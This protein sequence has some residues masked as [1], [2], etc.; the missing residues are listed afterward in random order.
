MSCVVPGRSVMC[1]LLMYSISIEALVTIIA[2]CWRVGLDL[3][4][5]CFNLPPHS[6]PAFYRLYYIEEWTLVHYFMYKGFSCS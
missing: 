2:T 6:L 4:V 1:E 3:S 5:M